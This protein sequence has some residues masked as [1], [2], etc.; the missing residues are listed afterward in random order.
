MGEVGENLARGPLPGLTYAKW[1]LASCATLEGWQSRLRKAAQQIALPS[2]S[3]QPVA[4]GYADWQAAGAP[5][6]WEICEF[7]HAA[8]WR[9]FLLD[10]WDK[11]KGTLLDHWA[12]GKVRRLVAAC[13]SA[14]LRVAL[15][16][17]LGASQIRQLQ[18][19]DPDWFAVR[20]SVCVRG[21]RTGMVSAEAVRRLVS[22]LSR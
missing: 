17:S 6:P 13:R 20:G 22:L 10:T 1:G 12:L 14:G 9:F 16:G 7:S 21:R 5:D 4:V 3:L 15:A 11:T 19:V 8:G 18:V 2:S